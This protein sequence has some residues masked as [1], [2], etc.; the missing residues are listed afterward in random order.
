MSLVVAWFGDDLRCGHCTIRPKVEG[1]V[2]APSRAP[3]WSVAGLTGRGDA[4][5]V[6]THDGGPAY[7]G[8]PSDAAVRAAI[9]DLKARGLGVT[10]YPI[11]LMDIPE[12]NP[13]GQP[14][15]PWRGRISCEAGSDGTAA[16][17][18]EVGGVPRE[19]RDF[20]AALCGARRCRRWRRCAD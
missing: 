7:G 3:S 15:Y 12:G 13:L 4:G 18:S 20:I 11:V 1:G 10:L 5:V 17:A 9:A 6:S 2:T 14:A 19:Y 8:T 16:A